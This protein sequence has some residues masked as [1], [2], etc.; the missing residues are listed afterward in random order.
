MLVAMSIIILS[1]LCIAMAVVVAMAVTMVMLCLALCTGAPLLPQGLVHGC[2]AEFS[3]IV[4]FTFDLES[5][6]ARCKY[7]L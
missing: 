1:R 2:L 6:L 7:L 3:Q 4:A 5:C